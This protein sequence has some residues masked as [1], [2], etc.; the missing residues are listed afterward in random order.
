MRKVILYILFF[1]F[2][3][4]CLETEVALNRDDYKLIDSFY[5]Q[6][7][8][9]LLPGLDMQC[10]EYRDSVLKIWVDSIVAKRQDEIDKLINR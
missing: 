10:A 8:E 1:S 7:K 5:N 9:L 3:T 4:G 6:E 2:L